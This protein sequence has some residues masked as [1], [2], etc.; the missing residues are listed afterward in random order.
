MRNRVD[1]LKN[2]LAR[3]E[4]SL[5]MVDNRRR[6]INIY[7]IWMLLSGLEFEVQLKL[8]LVLEYFGLQCSLP[9]LLV[10]TLEAS[11]LERIG[12]IQTVISIQLVKLLLYSL[13]LFLE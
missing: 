7:S 2:A 1:M 4:Q 9:M 6:L 3:F 5:P 8:V 12:M 13:L 10:S 11:L